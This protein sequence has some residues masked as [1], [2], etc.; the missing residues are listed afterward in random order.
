M[1]QSYQRQSTDNALLS[2]LFWQVAGIMALAI[3]LVAGWTY[4]GGASRRLI[5][6]TAKLD[7]T[8]HAYLANK[9]VHAAPGMALDLSGLMYWLLH[10][11]T[12]LHVAI[13]F[14]TLVELVVGI[15]L[16]IGFATR[17]M[18][19]IGLGLACT[20]MIIFGWMGTTCL[21]EWTMA[22][23]GFATAAVTLL[24]GGGRYA[25]DQLFQ[26]PIERKNIVWARWLTSGPLPL[27]TPQVIKFSTIMGIISIL[28]TVGFYG[29]NFGALVT[30][31]S[32]RI[33]NAHHTVTL[34]QAAIQGNLLKVHSYITT[35][36]DTQGA[37]IAQVTLIQN[38]HKLV[39][40]SA[41]S[42][43]D[44]TVVTIHNQFAPWSTC[45][46]MAYAVQCQLGSK[47]TWS[48]KLPDGLAFDHSQ[49]LTLQMN[50]VEGKAFKVMV[51]F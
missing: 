46:A 5:Y 26:G 50:N 16:I 27:S 45:K 39:T 43:K 13:I 31:L 2:P 38:G 49:P 15:G 32:K 29:Y 7:P 6:A 20:L 40:Y 34:S 8:S 21:D 23:L 47:A 33:D 17:L 11:G 3:R 36:P 44:K 4:W 1:S 51:Q 10:H 28:F 42:L 37:Y 41:S 25:V 14:F 35:G 22:S 19:I 48:F 9:L 12:L 24:T 18:S 30:P